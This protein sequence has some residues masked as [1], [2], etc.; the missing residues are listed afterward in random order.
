MCNLNI[1]SRRR[2]N[3]QLLD[4]FVAVG[5]PCL[6]RM[7][8]RVTRSIRRSYPKPPRPRTP[9]FASTM[10]RILAKSAQMSRFTEKGCSKYRDNVKLFRCVSG[11]RVLRLKADQYDGAE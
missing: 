6:L 9:C 5:Q 4:L 2:G 7:G 1:F 8:P 3:Y 10:Y 11:W